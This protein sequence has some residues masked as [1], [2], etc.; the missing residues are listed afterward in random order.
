MYFFSFLEECQLQIKPDDDGINTKVRA[1]FTST[2]VHTNYTT[3][4]PDTASTVRCILYDVDIP[5]CEDDE[6]EE[7]SA[8]K[9]L[10]DWLVAVRE[11]LR[12][13]Q[14]SSRAHADEITEEPGLILAKSIDDVMTQLDNAIDFSKCHAHWE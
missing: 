7:P 10:S 4:T 5:G 8:N 3:C 14:S 1:I 6:E 13:V 9:E 2:Q 11:H 12:T